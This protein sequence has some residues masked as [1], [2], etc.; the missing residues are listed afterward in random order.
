MFRV[1]GHKKVWVLD[2]GLPQWRAS[3]FN[4]E[5]VSP[6]DD[7]V[8]KSIAANRAVERVYNGDQVSSNDVVHTITK[9]SFFCLLDNYSFFGS[10]Q[11]NTISFQTEFQPNLFWALEKASDFF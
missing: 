1:F 7:A 6:D 2:G 5:N 4:V 10:V 8:L 11:I 3:G 9:H